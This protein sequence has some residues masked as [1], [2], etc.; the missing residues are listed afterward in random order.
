[1]RIPFAFRRRSSSR[2]PLL[3]KGSGL[4]VT[5][6]LCVWTAA[7]S[8]G[9]RG[10]DLARA[11]SAPRADASVATG[12]VVSDIG[13]SCWIVFQD[14]DDNYWFG[15]DG[16]GVCRY[17]GKT[18]TRFTTR[19]GLTGDRVRGID[20]H[21]PSGDILVTS[22]SGISRFDGERFQELPKKEMTSPDSLNEQ[23][24]RLD[25]DDVWLRGPLGPCRYD[26]QT[27]YALRLPKSPRE[28]EYLARNPNRP[29]SPY[30][31]W[32]VYRDRSGHL[33]LGTGYVGVCRYD[34]KTWNWMYESHMTE[35]GDAWFG[36][37][38][39]IEDE[40]GAFW[41]CNTKHR[42]RLTL[43]VGPLA[44][45]E[46]R[47]EQLAY[48][49]E[50]GVDPAALAPGESPIYF[51]SV[52]A[53]PA[54]E[55]WMVTYHKGVWRYDGRNMTHY[56]IMDGTEVV[57][58]YSIYRDRHDGLWLGTHEHGVYKFNGES[59]ERFAPR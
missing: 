26:G 11:S 23:G 56:P 29:W 19:D 58:L 5:A 53:D 1:M 13:A 15:S 36:F 24:W 46:N 55:L 51:Q 10:A 30:D 17:D 14:A 48:T 18:I 57:L 12:E 38:S 44:E 27:L 3:G 39:V 43:P 45:V 42:Y 21:G 8:G 22:L 50:P 25:P 54:G 7:C 4:P 9:Q 59:F 31:V 40:D 33:W 32:C 6:L 37:R 41:I 49:R 34:G 20:Q 2:R 28:D 16:N 47:F 52:V 35:V